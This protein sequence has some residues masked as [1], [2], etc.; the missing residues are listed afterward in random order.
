MLTNDIYYLLITEKRSL[1][2]KDRSKERAERGQSKF[3]INSATPSSSSFDL[4]H[5][6]AGNTPAPLGDRASSRVSSLFSAS[7]ASG[8]PLKP[9]GSNSTNHGPSPPPLMASIES[10]NPMAIK[11]QIEAIT[12][13]DASKLDGGIKKPTSELSVNPEQKAKDMSKPPIGQIEAPQANNKAMAIVQPTE[14]SGLSKDVAVSSKLKDD[15]GG[16]DMKKPISPVSRPQSARHA[17]KTDDLKSQIDGEK[18]KNLSKEDPLNRSVPQDLSKSHLRSELIKK[19]PQIPSENSLDSI[20]L[21]ENLMRS[22]KKVDVKSQNLNITPSPNI[23]LGEN[24]KPDES[25][26]EARIDTDKMKTDTSLPVNSSE[27][28][29]NTDSK[30]SKPEEMNL[31]KDESPSKPDVEAKDRTKDNKLSQRVLKAEDS[32]VKPTPSPDP[33]INYADRPANPMGRDD[34]ISLD[35]R[36]IEISNGHDM[37]GVKNHQVVVNK[38]DKR[39]TNLEIVD[40]RDESVTGK[41]GSKKSKTDGAKS[42]IGDETSGW[43]SMDGVAVTQSTTPATPAS[44]TTGAQVGQSL[45]VGQQTIG[46]IISPSDIIESRF[47]VDYNSVQS[48]S[49]VVKDG[50]KLLARSDSQDER[51]ILNTIENELEQDGKLKNRKYFVYIVHDGHLTARKECIARIELPAKRR[52]TLADL[53]QLIASSP[54]I[55]L[56]SLRRS[57]FKFVTETYRLLNEDEDAAILHQ[58]YPTQGV[59]LKINIAEQSENFA[60]PMY[61]GARSR[62]SSSS[63]SVTGQPTGSKSTSA[64]SRNRISGMGRKRSSDGVNGSILPAIQVNE[65]P[66]RST[67]SSQLR[68]GRNDRTRGRSTGSEGRG[69]QAKSQRMPGLGA[70]SRSGLESR[71]LRR[72]TGNLKPPTSEVIGKLIQDLEKSKKPKASKQIKKPKESLPGID[73]GSNVISGAKKL[74]TATFHR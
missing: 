53:R 68:N 35:R 10:R 21:P 1:R 5:P 73:I 74:F 12:Q 27:T 69:S 28:S 9:R 24:S 50:Q 63:N 55:S 54:D 26:T 40:I 39:K 25:N 61:R 64:T 36:S 16:D 71:T 18:C 47:N 43:I 8:D 13:L 48:G 32:I 6:S 34:V 51:S 33:S 20:E 60:Y 31:T 57:R 46:P 67:R 56:S 58:V 17:P 42:P 38:L 70:R 15:F 7:N 37:T 11:S 62:M 23:L 4:G 29:N 45:Q 59:F 3:V 22:F 30:T 65:Y 19:T 2:V 49:A 72:D 44:M 66:V 41:M 52:I 14:N